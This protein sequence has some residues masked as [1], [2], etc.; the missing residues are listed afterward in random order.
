MI[1]GRRPRSA[2]GDFLSGPDIPIAQTQWNEMWDRNGSDGVYGPL[3]GSPTHSLKCDHCMS[4]TRLLENECGAAA[5]NTLSGEITT[6]MGGMGTTAK[7]VPEK[8]VWLERVTKPQIRKLFISERAERR[9]EDTTLENVYHTRFYDV[10]QHP[11]HQVNEMAT[12]NRIKAKNVKLYSA[13][14]ARGT[15]EMQNQDGCQSST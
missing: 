1:C 6:A 14:L 4:W 15:I 9:R 12:V 2:A 7:I 13:R 5:G 3:V 11:P 8:V 10:L